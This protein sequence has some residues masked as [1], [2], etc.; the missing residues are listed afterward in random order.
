[1][2]GVIYKYTNIYNGKVYI[3]QTVN[4][5]KRREKWRNLKTP[6]A[7]SYINRARMKYGLE[8]FE[9]E[10][11]AEVTNRDE[12]ILRE[13]LN[14]LEKKYIALYQSKNPNFGYNLT[15]GGE[16]GNG[17][18]VSKETKDKISKAHKG[19]KKK[20]SEQ[21]KRNISLAHKSVRPW[22]WKKVA[23]YDKDTGEL[24]KIWNSL[25]EVTS[26][27][28]D[29]SNSNLVYAIQGKYRHKCYRGYKWKYYGTGS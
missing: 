24:I 20:M 26:H 7:G 27:F 16:S 3:G 10:V 17:Q 19:L 12:D 13:T 29:K 1:M 2:R 4:E 23:Q 14:S 25:S 9:Y 8:S 11:L 21:G 28:G 6:Y 15:D 22:A 5:Y 18:I